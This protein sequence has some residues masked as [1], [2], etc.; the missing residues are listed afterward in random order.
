VLPKQH[1]LT[2][3]PEFRATMRSGRRRSGV[4]VVTHQRASAVDA[5]ARFGFVVSKAVGGA[6]QRNRVKR[7]LR[8]ASAEGIAAGFT[9]ADVVVRALPAAADAAYAELRAE[10]LSQLG[11]GA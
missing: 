10:V 7:R 1:R 2:R 5:P 9:G 11:M 3:A 8:A 4:A 6:V